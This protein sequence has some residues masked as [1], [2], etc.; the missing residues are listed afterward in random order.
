MTRP[1]WST[2]KKKQEKE[3]EAT[4]TTA[5]ETASVIRNNSINKHT[6]IGQNEPNDDK[7]IQTLI[8]E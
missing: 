1:T 3:G 2:K 6:L 4:E 8:R 5:S 7:Q